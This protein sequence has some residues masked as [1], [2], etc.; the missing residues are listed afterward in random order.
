MPSAC[1]SLY[2]SVPVPGMLDSWCYVLDALPE[3]V[4]FIMPHL[5]CTNPTI[6]WQT[7]VACFGNHVIVFTLALYTI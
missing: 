2:Y 3:A 1:C 6:D 5:A 7:K 4:V